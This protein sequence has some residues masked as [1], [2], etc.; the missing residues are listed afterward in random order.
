MPRVQIRLDWK[1]MIKRD[2]AFV[3]GTLV[4]EMVHAFV[5]IMSNGSDRRD[6][7]DDE[8]GELFQQAA[9]R[10]AAV[11]RFEGFDGTDVIA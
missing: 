5:I 1:L 3:W 7:C 11:L 10:V 8:H 9:D 6:S 4:H 2:K